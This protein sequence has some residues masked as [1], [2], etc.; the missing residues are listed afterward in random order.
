MYSRL[1]DS[2]EHSNREG[3]RPST[4]PRDLLRSVE[5][6]ADAE[7]FDAST[8]RHPEECEAL[9]AIFK[10]TAGA[11]WKNSDNWFAETDLGK[12]HGVKIDDDGHVVELVLSDNNL[13]GDISNETLLRLHRLRRVQPHD[14]MDVDLFHAAA[15]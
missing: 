4:V 13:R 8:F 9:A 3:V 2:V 1:P 15:N 7:T 5:T 14:W 10:A 12:W 6:A 11:R